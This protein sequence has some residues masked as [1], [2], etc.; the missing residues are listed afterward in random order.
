MT[1]FTENTLPALVFTVPA[2]HPKG[3]ARG[4]GALTVNE[5]QGVDQA[6]FTWGVETNDKYDIAAATAALF[7]EAETRTPLSGAATAAGPT[8]AS[9]A[10]SN[11]VRHTNLSSVV[12]Q[13]ILSTQASGGGAHMTHVGAFRVYAHMQTPATNSGTVTVRLDWS[14][15]DI[16]AF[17][18]NDPV[19]LGTVTDFGG[20]WRTIDL[21]L[22]S[23]PAGA[24]RWE[25]RIAA[26]STT[27]G[28]DLDID[29]ILLVP[30]DHGSGIASIPA[31][32]PDS[33]AFDGLDGFTGI[34]SGTAL[35]ARVAP[36]GG[37]WAT[38]GAATDFAAADAPGA[39]ETESR[40]TT[41]DAS[42]RFA[43]LGA[44]TFTNVDARVSVG[45]STFTAA[46]LN[47]PVARWVDAS[48]YVRASFSGG[49]VVISVV[50][51]GVTVATFGATVSIG[52]VVNT[53]Y[54]VRLVCYASGRVIATVT[55][56]SLAVP[57]VVALATGYSSA[58]ATGGTLATGKAGFVDRNSG[59]NAATRYYDDFSA[60]S[61]VGDAAIMANKSARITHERAERQD[62]SNA[63]GPISRYE[64]DMLRIEPA[65][66]EQRQLRFVV[67]A[68]RNDP[69]I[70]SDPAIDDIQATLTYT[71]RYLSVPVPT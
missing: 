47:G 69:A 15:G 13:S 21:G 16:R 57:R 11:V 8:G 40:A 17:T 59:L 60:T 68:S 52:A 10:G 29:W 56:R 53:L 65:G 49:T 20:A 3:T 51:A 30:V 27:S 25:G 44:S 63:W 22:I 61:S 46:D 64:G 12:W 55:D 34:T 6:W 42:P 66:R 70:A 23:V 14:S 50:V 2:G 7:Y 24:T 4:L 41:S 9:G 1:T 67:K 26:I 39:L 38:S 33:G 18:A 45:Y 35:N 62:S 58:L 19:F 71:P 5:T 28:D 43:I 48:N 31:V 54:A 37:T 32:P 36:L